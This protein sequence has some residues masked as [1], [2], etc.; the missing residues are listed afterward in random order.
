MNE[1]IKQLAGQVDKWFKEDGH[2]YSRPAWNEKFADLIVR[3]CAE[4]ADRG[5]AAPGDQIKQ[6][7][8]V[9]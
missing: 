3:E 1:R 2:S 5:W 4:I 9:K 7:F 8:G 6:N